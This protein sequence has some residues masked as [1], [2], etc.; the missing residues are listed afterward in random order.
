MNRSI[1]RMAAAT[2]VATAAAFAPASSFAQTFS[3][4]A[5]SA[6]L[7][8]IP[9]TPA[10][11]LRPST[12]LPAAPPPVVAFTAAQLGLLPGDVI[13]AISFGNDAA[14][15]TGALYFSVTRNA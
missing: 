13:D 4:D 7:A 5:P 12:A 1:G 10:D 15:G 14:L 9:A 2:V 8:A 3:L 6:S 11:L